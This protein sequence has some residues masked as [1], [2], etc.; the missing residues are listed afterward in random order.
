MPPIEWVIAEDWGRLGV[1]MIN[2]LAFVHCDIQRWSPS[3][4]R[5]CSKHWDAFKENMRK[6]G[7]CRLFSMVSHEDTKV[8]KWQEIFGQRLVTTQNGLCLYSQEI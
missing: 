2:G 5:E 4:R 1:R 3:R 8:N 7:V 6:R